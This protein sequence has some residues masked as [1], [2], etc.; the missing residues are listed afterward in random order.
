VEQEIFLQATCIVSMT[1]FKK[2]Y[3]WAMLS[4]RK[5]QMRP[6]PVREAILSFLAWRRAPAGLEMVS[7][8]EGVRGKCDATTVYRTLMM[9]K[10]AELVRLV[11]TPRRASYFVLNAPGDSAHFLICRRCG[12]VTEL[13]LP[14]LVSAAI[15]RIA[16][17][18]GFSQTPQDCEVCGLCAHCQAASKTQV[19]PSKL[20]VGGC[21]HSFPSKT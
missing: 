9:F 10:E 21:R 7:Q 15:G 20:I 6:T 18:R 14:N 3:E 8:A 5:A 2:R 19:M 1:T 16:A 11:G 12:C 17:S 13:P 4:C